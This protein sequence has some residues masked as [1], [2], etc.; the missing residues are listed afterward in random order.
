LRFMNNTTAHLRA[1][2]GYSSGVSLVINSDFDATK[3]ELQVDSGS[4]CYMDGT[5]SPLH[6]KF[7]GVYTGYTPPITNAT[8]HIAGRFEV[9]NSVVFNKLI[10]DNAV[11]TVTTSGTA[12]VAGDDY[13][14]NEN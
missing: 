3:H 2:T 1:D 8:G 6:I 14:V 10:L 9:A 13:I 5:S 12:A 11:T 7:Y 4:A